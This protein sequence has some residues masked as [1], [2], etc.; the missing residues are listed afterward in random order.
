MLPYWN[1]IYHWIDF[2]FFHFI[3]LCFTVNVIYPSSY[4]GFT[5]CSFVFSASALI[6]I[7][8]KHYIILSYDKGLMKIKKTI[9][10]ELESWRE[11]TKI[12]VDLNANSLDDVVKKLLGK[13]KTR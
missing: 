9:T 6:L 2:S 7:E 11:L 5:V 1:L 13:W 3:T 4:F 8:R 12:K 10:I